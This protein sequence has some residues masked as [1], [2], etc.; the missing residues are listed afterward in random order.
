MGSHQFTFVFA[1]SPPGSGSAPQL[2]ASSGNAFL[3]HTAKAMPM[4]DPVTP[5]VDTGRLLERVAS[6]GNLATALHHVASNK[7]APGI[8]GRS[9]SDVVASCHEVLPTLRAALLSGTYEPGAVRR[10]WIPKPAGGQR[11]LGIPTVSS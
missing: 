7:G 8:D 3:L 4:E 5:E 9:V 11:G 6:P 2:D 10:V 1:D